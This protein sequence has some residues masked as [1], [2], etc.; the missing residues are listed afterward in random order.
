M[1]TNTG[2]N[3]SNPLRLQSALSLFSPSIKALGINFWT[4]FAL[5][6]FLPAFL[7]GCMCLAAVAGL[8]LTGN[9]SSAANI[10]NAALSI[11]AVAG[12][13]Y[14]GVLT[15]AATIL[16]QLA[17]VKGHA[18]GVR[19]ALIRTQPFF[20]R[21]F[22]LQIVRGLIFIGGLIL[23]VVPFFFALRRYIL[24]DYYLFEY[25][26]TIKQSLQMSADQS[27]QFSPAIWG[28][29]GVQVLVNI[30]PIMGQALTILYFCAPAVRFR[31]ITHSLSELHKH[32]TGSPIAETHNQA[33]PTA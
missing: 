25:N 17:S 19:E 13:I 12:A 26:L 4:F 2:Q 18:I 23:F 6:L 32:Q 16:V 7:V 15:W 24:A 31:E 30:L 21:W 5:M 22:G 29:I 3:N 10:I 1:D 28:L 20:W 14:I 8:G 9:Q 11:V 27:K 33:D